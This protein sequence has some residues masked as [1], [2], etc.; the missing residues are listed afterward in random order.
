[1][2]GKVTHYPYI[3]PNKNEVMFNYQALSRWGISIGNEQALVVNRPLSWFER[4]HKELKTLG[5][6]VLVMGSVIILL[7]LMIRHL[8]RS[9]QQLQRSQALFENGI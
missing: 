6:V 3:R 9:E 1:M 2:Q 4:H 8:R 7:S 5:F